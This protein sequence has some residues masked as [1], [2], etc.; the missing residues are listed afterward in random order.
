MELLVQR[1]MDCLRRV[2]VMVARDDDYDLLLAALDEASAAHEQLVQAM[3]ED[4]ET[5]PAA[6]HAFAL[7]AGNRL[8][9]LCELVRGKRDSEVHARG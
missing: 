6:G 3:K 1:L 2:D 7:L 8:L 4:V 5:V 9:S